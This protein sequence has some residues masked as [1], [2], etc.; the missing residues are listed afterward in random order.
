MAKPRTRFPSAGLSAVDADL[1]TATNGGLG[2]NSTAPETAT[3]CR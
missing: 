3:T 2:V 1:N